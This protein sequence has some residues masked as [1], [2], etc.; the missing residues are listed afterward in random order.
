MTSKIQHK[1]ILY[2]FVPRLDKYYKI[3]EFNT[4]EKVRK[5]LIS[6]RINSQKPSYNQ[7]FYYKNRIPQGSDLDDY[8]IRHIETKIE[9]TILIDEVLKDE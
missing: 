2:V 4:L 3:V 1:Y 8:Y 7:C 5:F 9:T 6:A